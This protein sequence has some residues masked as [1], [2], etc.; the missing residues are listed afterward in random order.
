MKWVQVSTNTPSET[1]ELWNDTAK[2]AGVSFSNTS[3]IVRMVSAAGKRLFF[4]EKKGWFSPKAIIK[5]EYGITLGKLQTPAENTARGFIELNGKKYHYNI[6]PH[7]NTKLDLYDAELNKNIASCSFKS[8]LTKGYN[9]TSSLM[10]SRFPQLL[11]LLC[12]YSLHLHNNNAQPAS[13]SL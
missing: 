3:R 10:N 13:F 7:D 6:N 9:K 4:Y 2:V 5:N 1:F 12:W 8:V 11:L